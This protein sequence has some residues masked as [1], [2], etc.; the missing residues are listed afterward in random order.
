MLAREITVGPILII[1]EAARIAEYN[2]A[3]LAGLL[4]IK[5]ILIGDVLQLPPLVREDKLEAEAGLTK[6]LFH[7]MIH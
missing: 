3:S 5:I 7:K 6:S 2:I 1:E 4:P